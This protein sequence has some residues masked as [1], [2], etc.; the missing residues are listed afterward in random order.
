[1]S[2]ASYLLNQHAPKRQR[3]LNWH[4]WRGHRWARTHPD[5]DYEQKYADQ[6]DDDSGDEDTDTDREKVWDLE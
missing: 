4:G 6:D 1:L 2:S 5:P 3:S